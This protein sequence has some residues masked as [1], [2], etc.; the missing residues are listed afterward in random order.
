MR[1][2]QQLQKLR[3]RQ[4]KKSLEQPIGK[5]NY[6]QESLLPAPEEAMVICVEEAISVSVF[7]RPLPDTGVEDFGLPWL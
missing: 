4:E 7:G 3:A 5:F 6:L 1:R 2:E